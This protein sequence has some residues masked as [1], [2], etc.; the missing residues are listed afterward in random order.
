MRLRLTDAAAACARRAYPLMVQA[1]PREF[2]LEF[3]D[4]MIQAFGDLTRDV[5][6][7]SGVA[8]LCRL[9][10][11]TLRD[12]VVSLLIS[13]TREQRSSPTGRAV[14]AALFLAGAVT[15]AVGYGGWRFHDFYAAPSFS[16]FGA[17]GPVDEDRLLVA[18]AVALTGDFGRFKAYVIGIGG[19]L[20]VL[21]GAAAGLF[22]VAQRSVVHGAAAL[23]TGGLC[24][25][26]ALSLL[27]TI[28]FP[29]DRYP[30]GFLWALAGL[31]TAATIAAV[32]AA[33]GGSPLAGE[34]SVGVSPFP[35]PLSASLFQQPVS[36]SC[37]VIS[38]G[39]NATS[40]TAS[41]R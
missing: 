40:P 38:P 3:G 32:V 15:M 21:L 36:P 14:V 6:R 19:A 33:A 7:V 1:F 37:R 24:T 26:A 29:L 5:S 13:Y 11:A 16:Q 34:R 28:W 8:G 39:S 10:L 41:G 12:T 30:A 4:D 20:A 25:V 27:P 22:G 31:P 23:A 17:S 35:S 18:Y 9:W 2:R